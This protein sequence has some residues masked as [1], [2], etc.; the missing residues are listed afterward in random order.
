MTV[1]KKLFYIPGPPVQVESI[2][3]SFLLLLACLPE[4]AFIYEIKPARIVPCVWKLAHQ[5]KTENDIITSLQGAIPDL[6]RL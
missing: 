5:G 2:R 1:G 6:T 3:V 4:T